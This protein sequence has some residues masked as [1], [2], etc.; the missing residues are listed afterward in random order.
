[1][2]TII[3]TYPCTDKHPMNKD[4][5]PPVDPV[6]PAKVLRRFRV[7]FNAIRTHFRLIEKQVGLGGAQVW[8]LSIIKGKPGI[9]MLGIAADMQIHQSTASNLIKTLLRKE[10]IT[11]EKAPE[12]RRNVRLEIRPAGLKLLTKV[13]VPFEGVLPV[14]LGNL[15]AETLMRMDQDLDQLIALLKADETAGE[16]PLAEI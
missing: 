5:A 6:T 2:Q 4:A 7:I 8:A 1:M 14:A 3:I 13:S 11:M 15:S 12:D 9:G 10:L 16:T